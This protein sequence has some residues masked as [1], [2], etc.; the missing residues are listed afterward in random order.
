MYNNYLFFNIIL[1]KHI[2]VLDTEAVVVNRSGL[3]IV[4][5]SY[6]FAILAEELVSGLFF[7]YVQEA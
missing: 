2:T 3:K 1:K 6:L 7:S 5:M 4:I